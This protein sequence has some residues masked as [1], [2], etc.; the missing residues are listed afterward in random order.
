MNTG[1]LAQCPRCG[2]QFP[3]PELDRPLAT[4]AAESPPARTG[5]EFSEFPQPSL[6]RFPD[7]DEPPHV[8]DEP[9]R[10]TLSTPDD[11]DYAHHRRYYEVDRSGP[12]SNDYTIEVGRWFEYATPHYSMFLGPAIGFIILGAL[13]YG[14]FVMTGL[15]LGTA[16]HMA[17]YVL[18]VLSFAL[19]IHP[20]LS[21]GFTAVALLQIQGQPWTFGDFWSGFPRMG[22]LVVVHIVKLLG[23]L[24]A[25]APILVM[26]TLEELGPRRP[27]AGP[28]PY[29]GVGIC[30][31]MFVTLPVILYFGTRLLCFAEAL[32]MD[33]GYGPIQAMSGSWELSRGH[34]WGLHGICWLY[35]LILYAGVM[36]CYVGALFTTP[37]CYLVWNAGYLLIAGSRP[38][39]RTPVR[40]EK[41]VYEEKWWEDRQ[42]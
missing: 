38:P 27:G 11:D 18:L 12:L 22:S 3:V 20:A 29:I 21:G 32:I 2:Q 5:Q 16:I 40:I 34:F 25:Y 33:R 26:I 10:P 23:G 4:P 41:G 6:P 17:I 31:G 8:T 36:G 7:R 14:F 42:R 15:I 30:V 1:D 39:V 24:V 19:L 9:R 13:I 37:L 35:Y 28:P